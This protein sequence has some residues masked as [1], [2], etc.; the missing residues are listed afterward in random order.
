M[1][2]LDVF[3]GEYAGCFLDK[4][5]NYGIFPL[6]SVSLEYIEIYYVLLVWSTS[7][8]L[9]GHEHNDQ[10]ILINFDVEMIDFVFTLLLVK[11]HIW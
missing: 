5:S 10:D 11:H 3:V 6:L 1:F 7:V 8:L 9:C 2:C 4:N